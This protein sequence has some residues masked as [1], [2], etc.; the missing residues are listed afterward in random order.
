MDFQFGF[1]MAVGII[2][3]LGGYVLKSIN[4]TIDKLQQ[5][6]R[7]LA[8][9]VQKIEVLVAGEYVKHSDLTEMSNAIFAR[10][11]KISD[12]IDRKMDKP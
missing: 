5:A 3:F 10:L 4:D 8:E 6:D 9:K 12:K 11:D 1:N 2:A 7:S